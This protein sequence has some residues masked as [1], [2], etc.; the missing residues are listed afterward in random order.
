MFKIV[1]N[2]KSKS[3]WIHTEVSFF[4]VI[5]V[6]GLLINLGFILEN[7]PFLWSYHRY[8]LLNQHC[9]AVLMFLFTFFGP[10]HY[11]QSTSINFIAGPLG[12][13]YYE[14]KKTSKMSFD[15]L[16]HC[17]HK[18]SCEDGEDEAGDEL[19]DDAVQPEG[20]GEVQPA[21][22]TPVV[23]LEVVQRVA[24][25]PV[26]SDLHARRHLDEQR[27]RD[28]Q[29]ERNP[30]ERAFQ[31]WKTSRPPA[32]IVHKQNPFCKMWPRL[33]LTFTNRYS[34]NRFHLELFV[35]VAEIYTLL[36]NLL[37]P[38]INLFHP[39]IYLP[40]QRFIY[41]I[42]RSTYTFHI[43]NVQNMFT[44]FK[45]S[46]TISKIHYRYPKFINDI[47]NWFTVSKINLPYPKARTI[48]HLGTVQRATA[49]EG[50]LIMMNLELQISQHINSFSISLIGWALK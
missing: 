13:T 39:M 15:H 47:Q 45:G 48:L 46:Y 16:V 25:Q 10:S 26:V 28:G 18:A 42:W 21:L 3:L 9:T 6:E 34:R 14:P 33:A 2:L 32:E 40:F 17:P 38:K 23:D 19:E 29:D 43:Q 35:V 8:H 20:E 11:P 50:N 41:F 7:L 24:A 31:C 4:V 22:Q 49:F 12:G 37:C 44:L 1:A 27:V 30:C 36:I 5:C